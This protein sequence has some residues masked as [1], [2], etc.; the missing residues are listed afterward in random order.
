M[1]ANL[2][3]GL[4]L[5]YL[6][7]CVYELEVRKH[8]ISAGLTKVDELHKTVTK[9]TCA[10]KQSEIMKYLID[11]SV[12]SDEEI[13]MFKRG[14]NSKVNKTRKNLS[15]QDYLAATGFESLMGYLYLIKDEKRIA[16][17]VK[18]SLTL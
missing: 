15:N 11:Y 1:N 4:T 12:L 5:A 13:L 8:F 2:Y 17:L 14:R 6:G 18:I 16:E 3:N 7:D 9:Y 10:E